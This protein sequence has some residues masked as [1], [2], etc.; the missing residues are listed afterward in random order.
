MI[1]RAIPDV[2]MWRLNGG[3]IGRL[4][5]IELSVDYRRTPKHPFPVTVEDAYAAVEWDHSTSMHS[6]LIQIVL[7][8]VVSVWET[9]SLHPRH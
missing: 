7:S 4:I 3:S 5:A 1:P 9:I 2:D 6:V 8:S